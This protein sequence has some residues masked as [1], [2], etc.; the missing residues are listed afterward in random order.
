MIVID[1]YNVTYLPAT[2]MKTL[3]K[4]LHNFSVYILYRT[5]SPEWNVLNNYNVQTIHGSFSPSSNINTQKQ[6][7][8][9]GS[10]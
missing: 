4:I 7:E 5:G 3:D 6:N 10:V 1:W 8:R 9:K 2:I